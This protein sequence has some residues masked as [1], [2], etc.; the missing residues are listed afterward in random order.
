MT[1]EFTCEPCADP[2]MKVRGHK[3]IAL[4]FYGL[5]KAFSSVKLDQKSLTVTEGSRPDIYDASV[6]NTQ[7]YKTIRS[8]WLSKRLMPET[9]SIEVGGMQSS[10]ANFG[11]SSSYWYLRNPADLVNQ[12]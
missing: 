9:V 5:I 11:A 12:S 1:P 7:Q 8:S 4:E 6:E 10:G 2:L 3:D